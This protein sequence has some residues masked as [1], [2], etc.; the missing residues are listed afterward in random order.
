MLL[1]YATTNAVG[2]IGVTLREPL[3]KI[4]LLIH[5][6]LNFQFFCHNKINQ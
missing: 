5:P 4:Q 2:C 1:A 6:N 3:A